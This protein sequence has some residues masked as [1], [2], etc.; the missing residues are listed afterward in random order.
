[1]SLVRLQRLLVQTEEENV[2]I[3]DDEVSDSI[4]WHKIMKCT[5]QEVRKTIASL[6]CEDNLK[7]KPQQ[8]Q[9]QQNMTEQKLEKDKRSIEFG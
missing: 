7:G 1:M 3:Q 9:E 5:D 2:M 8:H 6:K 4:G